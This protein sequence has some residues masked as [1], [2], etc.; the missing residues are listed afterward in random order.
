[1]S[2]TGVRKR[3][4]T[5]DRTDDTLKQQEDSYITKAK[6]FTDQGRQETG[7]AGPGAIGGPSIPGASY[8]PISGKYGMIGSMA[9]NPITIAIIDGRI[10]ITPDQS[11][12]S[13]DS[14]YILV[15][16]QGSPDDLRFIDGATKNGQIFWFQGTAT[17]IIN[18]KAATITTLSSISGVGIVTVVTNT[19]HNMLTGDKTNILGTNNFNI[20]D[21][22]VTVT[23]TTSFTYSALGSI[24][25][26]SVGVVQNGNVVTPNGEDIIL[27]GSQSLNGV[28][29][30][31]LI[32]DPTIIGFGAW[33][34][35]Q[36]ISEGGTSGS[37]TVLD[38]LIEVDHGTIGLVS[39]NFDW[40][41]GNFH[42]FVANGDVTV[43]FTNL[44]I[45]TKWSPFLLKIT[46]DGTGGHAITFAQSFEN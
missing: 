28:P 22:T 6:R 37:P 38:N 16:G 11:G 27:D 42:R 24:I 15:T 2:S 10:N 1:M 14:S 29:M 20:N 23:S 45:S 13:K 3:R 21:V 39:E 41:E 8:L 44:P 4:T 34:P 36:I 5:D 31:P 19:V 7:N 33:R 46:Q 26:E 18:I 30:V 12:G 32:F 35:A 25:S 43:G 9:F 40:K 17:Q